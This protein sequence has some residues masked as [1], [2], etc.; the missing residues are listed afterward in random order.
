MQAL[1]IILMAY[2]TSP[3]LALRISRARSASIGPK[4]Q[5]ASGKVLEC[6]EEGRERKQGLRYCEP[7]PLPVSAIFFHVAALVNDAS[8]LLL[9]FCASAPDAVTCRATRPANERAN[10]IALRGSVPPTGIREAKFPTVWMPWGPL[11]IRPLPVF[12]LART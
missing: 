1:L 12:T 9:R 5:T 8:Q 7:R 6:R 10:G 2:R 4:D 11:W 3:Q